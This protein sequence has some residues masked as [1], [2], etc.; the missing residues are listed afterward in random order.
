MAEGVHGDHDAGLL[1]G[2]YKVDSAGVGLALEVVEVRAGVEASL[3]AVAGFEVR[4]LGRARPGGH[5]YLRVMHALHPAAGA[6]ARRRLVHEDIGLRPG[7]EPDEGSRGSGGG[8]ARGGHGEYQVHSGVEVEEEHNGRARVGEESDEEEND[9]VLEKKL[10]EGR[11]TR[12]HKEA[13]GRKNKDDK[14]DE[15]GYESFVRARQSGITSG[16]LT[17]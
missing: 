13:S 11:T 3:V 14:I 8:D 5:R 12:S 1:G 4:R 2:A 10:P 17:V 15:H 9:A 16:L 7:A 6:I